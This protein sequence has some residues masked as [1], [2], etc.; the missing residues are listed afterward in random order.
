M[1]LEQ[2]YSAIADRAVDISLS[3]TVAEQA[4]LHVASSKVNIVFHN[5]IVF[6]FRGQAGQG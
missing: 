1:W 2:V 6:L 4:Q 3:V 5:A